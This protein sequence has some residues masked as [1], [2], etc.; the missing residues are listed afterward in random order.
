TGKTTRA[1]NGTSVGASA[2]KLLGG[3]FYVLGTKGTLPDYN[4]TETIVFD[5]YQ[6]NWKENSAG[7]T[8]DNT[9]DWE[10]VGVT[11]TG[12][13]AG[14]NKITAQSIKYWDYSQPH[15]DF[16][17]Y[18]VG[19]NILATSGDA[20]EGT[21]VGSAI[22]TPKANAEKDKNYFS[23]YLK[24]KTIEDLQKC[25]YTD[26]TPVEKANYKKPVTF[27]FKNLTAK[28]RV[29]FYEIIPGYTVSDIEFYDN[30]TD[31]RADLTDKK[32]AV[33][34][35]TGNTKLSTNGTINVT[36]P[37][38]GSKNA[39]DAAFNKAFVSIV[40]GTEDQTTKLGLGNVN[41]NNNVLNT[42]AK[43]ANMAGNKDN[44]YFSPVLPA[45]GHAHT[46]RLNY[47]LTST[48]GSNEK[49]KVYGATAVVPASYT[50][51]Q[52]N[53]AYTYIFKISDNTNGATNKEDG[54]PE[55][56]FPIT[57][58]AVVA[59]VDNADFSHES[60]TTVATPSVTTY[61]FNSH[62]KKVIKAYG[63]GNEYPASENTDIYFSVS[64]DGKTMN[65]LNTKGQLYNV[66]KA[67][68]TE[69]TVIDALQISASEDENTVTGRND[70]V[71]TKV[72][73]TIVN[74]IPKE[75]GK[76]IEVGNNT[77][78]KFTANTAATYAYVYLKEAGK[79]SA[80]YT[81]I[82]IGEGTTITAGNDEYFEDPSGKKVVTNGTTLTVGTTYYKKYTNN[83]NIYGV[84]VV[85]TYK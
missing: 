72:G 56:L 37:K 13:N 76:T 40:T 62:D 47:T 22:Q 14:G 6:V 10:Y 7:T 50:A 24:G 69:A 38:V 55:G 81:A 57:F 27:T 23:Y 68:A 75:D 71:L 64:E 19:D 74:E 43:E 63:V 20:V 16:I 36:Y 48:D 11:P 2:A 46:L 1:A 83:N 8:T 54:T 33:L 52:P 4:P 45:E 51:W 39:S 3:K 17:A 18:S 32:E 67:D 73:T 85:K 80:I 31:P 30:G 70:I 78:A 12:L 82:T 15:Y 77:T 35:T 59:D 66:S 61:A 42:T 5:N 58:D 84:K 9:N 25:Y 44:S 26:V 60:I 79:P 49:I 28:V 53:Y 29:A 21:I 34:Y 65:D 41:Y